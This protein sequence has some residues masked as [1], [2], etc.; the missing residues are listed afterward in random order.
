MTSRDVGTEGDALQ[1]GTPV[2]R[3]GSSA[4][5][6]SGDLYRALFEAM[7]EGVAL[8]EIVRD[9]EGLAVDYRILNVN[10]AF[11]AHTGI[12]AET[13]RGALA[14]VLYD[15][16]VP[17]FLDVYAR[18]ADTGTRCVF[19]SYF[20]P[21]RRHFRV[22]AIS[23]MRGFFA[24][25]FEDV[26]EH[27]ATTTA[28]RL[29][30]ARLRALHEI[31]HREFISERELI[32]HALELAVELTGSAVGYVHFVEDQLSAVQLFTWSKAARA[33]CTLPRGAHYPL[34]HA[35]IWADPIRTHGPA[36]H[37]DYASE[38]NR[39]GYPKG[40]PHIARHLGTCV[41]ERGKVVL[42]GGVANKPTDYHDDD[43][44]QLQLFLD[45]V[46]RA[47]A[48]KRA[49][50][51]LRRSETEL[52][53]V[54]H[55]FPLATLVWERRGDDFVLVEINDA[56]NAIPF[57][58]PSPALGSSAQRARI[59]DRI[60][61]ELLVQAE[62]SRETWRE[63]LVD[64]VADGSLRHLIVTCSVVPPERVV[65]HVEDVSEQRGVEEQLRSAQKMEA[66]GRLA[67]G[68]AHDFN[69]ILSVILSG[70]E[71]ALDPTSSAESIRTDLRDIHEA[72]T[73]AAQLT[74]Q[75][76]AF[77][78][79]QVLQPAVVDVNAIVF[80]LEKML[81][82]LLGEHVT[83]VVECPPRLGRVLADAGQL[84][85]VLMNLAVNARD[86]MPHGGRLEI[87]TADVEL[88]DGNVIAAAEGAAGEFV[89]LAV[90]DTGV[91]IDPATRARLFEPFFSTKASGKGTG[92]GL[93]TVWGIVRQSGGQIL[94]R[95][96]PGV[97]TTFEVLLPRTQERERP[98]ASAPASR[99]PGTQCGT[100]LLAED[101][102][103][104]RM[105]AARILKGAGYRVV[106]AADGFE[107]LRLAEAHAGT[108][109]LLLTDIVM[110]GMS[111]SVLA[112]RL[113]GQRPDLRVLFMSGHAD[114]DLVQNGVR[115]ASSRFLA[116]PF[117][118][119]SLLRRVRDAISATL[120]DLDED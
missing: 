86:A 60:L 67:G 12:E 85:Q 15:E 59:G 11:V 2:E 51:A 55:H 46:W 65:V 73:R 74:R 68:V 104:V 101:E 96:E 28:L 90:S 115:S 45:G 24:T 62:A 54:Y 53:A 43:V 69:N 120:R 25:I 27:K 52:R 57:G 88:V 21:L 38:P 82:R 63:E 93:A 91:G 32:D 95:S 16:A 100:I 49:D 18:V 35:G 112:K 102:D 76:L 108:F 70:A 107:A 119:T 50:E 79:R 117:D 8:H 81:R 19:E 80:G 48:K 6:V 103:A 23:P 99:R 41:M 17:P 33:E 47:I 109:D 58:E 66:I 94:V 7:G 113:R 36:V 116:K 75:L 20:A 106:S 87:K 56:A 3:A 110:P 114:D 9:A 84:E 71:L 98:S 29:S 97:G 83:L 64:A 10:A 5:P 42:V 72:G 13:A 14:T 39:A 30:E 111:G 34:E 61:L 31:S 105:L 1:L 77:S 92:L 37:N 44:Q 22:V 78:R 40:H 4:P 26:T 89:S 118:A